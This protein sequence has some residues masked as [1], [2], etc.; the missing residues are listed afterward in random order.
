MRLVGVGVGEFLRTGVEVPT[1]RLVVDG[2]LRGER[3]ELR[4]GVGG[5]GIRDIANIRDGYYGI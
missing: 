1:R 2:F 5:C 4:D 3:D